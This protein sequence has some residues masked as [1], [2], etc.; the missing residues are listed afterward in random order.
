[1]VY[2]IFFFTFF[3]LDEQDISGILYPD[4]NDEMPGSQFDLH[5]TQSQTDSQMTQEAY[6]ENLP[7][8]TTTDPVTTISSTHQVPLPSRAVGPSGNNAENTK[9]AKEDITA[10]VAYKSMTQHTVES[11]HS[12]CSQDTVPVVLGE[13]SPA[14]SINQQPSTSNNTVQQYLLSNNNPKQATTLNTN[15]IEKYILS[16]DAIPEQTNPQQSPTTDIT[17]QQVI[18]TDNTVPR[19]TTPLNTN[20]PSSPTIPNQPSPSVQASTNEQPVV[21]PMLSSE[22]STESIT[23]F[24]FSLPPTVGDVLVASTCT[25]PPPIPPWQPPERDTN[26]ETSSSSG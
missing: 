4:D 26:I 2:S 22:L 8:L 18:T 11:S 21:V 25:T 3:F 5:L 1:M 15:T 7:L 16:N 10:A 19:V 9:Q 17:I 12:S 20:K 24:H 14:A 13:K 23:N 6:I